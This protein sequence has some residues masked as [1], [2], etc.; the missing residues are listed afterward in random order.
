MFEKFSVADSFEVIL[1]SQALAIIPWFKK[2]KNNFKII[3]FSIPK[4]KGYK[5][6]I[7]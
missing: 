1:H 2:I 7:L 4:K 3:I 5:E 6:L